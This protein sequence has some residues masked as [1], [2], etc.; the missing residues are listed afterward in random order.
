ML[1][2]AWARRTPVLWALLPP[3]AIGMFEKLVF[4]TTYF[5]FM[6]RYRMIGAMTEAFGAHTGGNIDRLSQLDPA[7]FLSAPGLW[8]GLIFTIAFLIGAMRLRRNRE[9]I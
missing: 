4:N 7:R 5:G 2:S 8:V 9:A 6:L 1:I 3:F